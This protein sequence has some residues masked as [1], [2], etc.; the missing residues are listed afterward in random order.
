MKKT[1]LI[2]SVFL[3]AAFTVNAQIEAG[4]ISVGGAV[5]ISSNSSKY[6]TG[7]NTSDGPKSSQFTIG[8]QIGYFISDNISIGA[9]LAFQSSVSHNAAGNVKTVRNNFHF[10]PFGRYH[11]PLSEKFYAFG[12]AKLNF[13]FGSAKQKND[14]DTNKTA[15]VST[16]G[17]AVSPGIIFFPSERIGIELAFNLL[18]F[19]RTADK[20]PDNSD[21]KSIDSGFSFGPDLFAPSLGIQLYF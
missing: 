13:G 21:N 14:G 3:M 9:G 16:L 7:S 19:E 12:E 18:S 10:S 20:D 8:P 4:N 5:N 17:L 6:K 2:L 11:I 15:D 1:I